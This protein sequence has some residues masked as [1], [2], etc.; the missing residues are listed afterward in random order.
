MLLFSLEVNSN[1]YGFFLFSRIDQLSDWSG[2]QRCRR[3][4][5]RWQPQQLQSQRLLSRRQALVRLGV[6]SQARSVLRRRSDGWW[7]RGS[8]KQGLQTVHLPLR[9]TPAHRDVKGRRLISRVRLNIMPSFRNFST[10][11]PS[12]CHF[13]R[14]SF[15]I[16]KFHIIFFWANFWHQKMFFCFSVSVL[17]F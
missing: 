2:D 7:I 17:F 4:D 12:Q 5:D 14:I 3:S 10:T 9:A 8:G 13:F 6:Q 16:S 15:F 1:P 11:P